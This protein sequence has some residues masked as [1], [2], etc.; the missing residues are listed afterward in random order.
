MNAPSSRRVGKN[1][2]THL[3]DFDAQIYIHR[4]IVDENGCIVEKH[5][6][7]SHIAY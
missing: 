6:I 5:F 4:K 2:G 3:V 1:F 7:N